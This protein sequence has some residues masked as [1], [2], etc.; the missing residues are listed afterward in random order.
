[1]N[2]RAVPSSLIKIGSPTTAASNSTATTMKSRKRNAAFQ[3]N[4][5]MASRLCMIF[6][7]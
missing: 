3:V 1:M 6:Q 4:Q 7:V 2:P 5:V